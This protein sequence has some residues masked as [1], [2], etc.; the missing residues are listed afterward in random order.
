MNKIDVFNKL[1]A[2]NLISDY[3]KYV[4]VM[5]GD[6]YAISDVVL[7][8]FCL[9]FSLVDD[10]NICISLDSET[11]KEKWNKKIQTIDEPDDINYEEI[12]D[13]GILEIKNYTQDINSPWIIQCDNQHCQCE[14]NLFV[15]YNNWLF[16]D[17]FFNAKQTIKH[18]I[19]SPLFFGGT[20]PSNTD[21][22]NEVRD[23]TDHYKYTVKISGAQT[24]EFVLSPE[25]A[26]AIAR[27][28]HGQNLIITGGP[29]TGKTTIVCYLLMELLS[30]N[31][32]C[33]IYMAAPSGKAAKRMKESITGSLISL[34]DDIKTQQKNIIDVINNVKP[35]TIHSLLNRAQAGSYELKKLPANSIFIIDE[36]SMIDVCL[37]AKLMNVINQTDNP[38]V[39]IL[40]DHEQLPS[41]QPGAVFCELTAQ[42]ND[43]IIRLNKTHRFPAGSE[44]YKLKQSI[45]NQD[46][47]F[48]QNKW[49]HL[50]D[51]WQQE[52]TQEQ[53][54]LKNNNKRYPVRYLTIDDK[55]DIKSAVIQWYD[56]FYNDDEYRRVYSDID[57][58]AADIVKTLDAIWTHIE[59]AKILCAENQGF[60]QW[61]SAQQINKIICDYIKNA[62]YFTDNTDGDDFFTGEQIII[63]KNQQMYDLSNGDI[64][65]L[66]SGNHKKYIMI[67]RT[68]TPS[69]LHTQNITST[70]DVIKRVG[71]YVLYPLYLLSSDSVEAA[72]AITIHKSQGSEYNN[73]LVFLPQKKNSPLLNRQILYTAITRTKNATYIV[74][75]PESMA[76]AICTWVQRD[77]Q[78][79]L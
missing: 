73:I 54:C 32:N 12:I 68:L 22:E 23:I 34:K 40:G 4:L 19:N 38:R 21:I 46:T 61:R 17:K 57:L 66:I 64:G 9:F 13:N 7:K 16:T 37:F 70:Q 78:L 30:K 5:L 71:N 15:V 1:K 26:N 43:C 47:E 39:F 25:Q 62:D 56:A 36:A 35:L 29:G 55:D 24:K 11:L 8:L 6:R 45:Q 42:T 63:T 59:Q 53:M 2:N 69:E 27:A 52:L 31:G 72:Y 41:V 58:G 28:K 67:K 3:W 50:S 76:Q 14:N 18:I 65:I 44:I 74:S 49:E 77:T 20:T 75:G 33:N 48:I 79:F 51:A 10:G 60:A